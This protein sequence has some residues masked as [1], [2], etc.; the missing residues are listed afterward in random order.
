MR[1]SDG[2]H[3]HYSLNDK[4]LQQLRVL[5]DRLSF[6]IW[7]LIV[8]EEHSLCQVAELVHFAYLLDKHFCPLFVRV[9]T[10]M[11]CFNLML[12]PSFLQ[13]SSWMSWIRLETLQDLLDF[14]FFDGLA[15]IQLW[16]DLCTLGLILGQNFY[17][18]E[19][20]FVDVSHLVAFGLLYSLLNATLATAEAR[21]R[22]LFLS[23]FN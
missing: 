22:H 17:I 12:Q 13:E 2:S 6:L 10:S 9:E 23:Y 5:P 18:R 21:L 19:L 8:L 1:C 11:F 16:L 14:F 3:L 15:L 4:L 7:K 20:L